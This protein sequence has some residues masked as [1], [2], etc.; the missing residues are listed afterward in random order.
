MDRRSPF[1][2]LLAVSVLGGMLT[3]CAVSAP[4][5]PPQTE[6]S[7]AESGEVAEAVVEASPRVASVD[8]I[9]RS[10]NGAGERLSLTLRLKSGEPMTANELDAVAEAIWTAL[11]WEPNAIVIVAGVDGSSSEPV[12]LR[13]AAAELEPM[14]FTD[15][16]QGGVSLFDMDARYGA[17]TAP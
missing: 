17:W 7:S 5:S 2:L 11:P 16:G 10:R 4:Q 8:D 12:D 1:A 6:A 15:A 9:G 13:R 3:G 14:G